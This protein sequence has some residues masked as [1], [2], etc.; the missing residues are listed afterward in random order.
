MPLGSTF[1]NAYVMLSQR[2]SRRANILG[3]SVAFVLFSVL[4]GCYRDREARHEEKVERKEER[5][6]EKYEERH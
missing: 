2:T 4:S 6:H 5:K 1:A 3:V